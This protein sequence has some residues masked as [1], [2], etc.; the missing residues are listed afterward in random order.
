MFAPNPRG[1]GKA[2]SSLFKHLVPLMPDSWKVTFYT[3]RPGDYAC[4]G[5]TRTRCIDMRGDRFNAWENIRLPLA[6]LTDGINLLHCPSQTAPPLAPCPVILTVHDLIPLRMND[7]WSAVEVNRFRKALARSVAKSRRIITVSEFTKRDLMAFCRVPEDKVD[8]V[9]WGVDNASPSAFDEEQWRVFC[10]SAGIVSPYFIA[11]GG[12]APR[13]NVT[14]ILEAFARFV[15]EVSRDVQLLLV[16]VPSEA[17]EKF[18]AAAEVLDPSGSVVQLGY[19]P[20]ELIRQTLT[21]SEALVYPSLYEGFGLPI[22]EAMV[23]GA[24]VITSN[25]TSMPEIAGDAAL[26]VNPADPGAIADAMHE[27]FANR[28]LRAELK[29]RGFRRIDDFSW[30]LAARQTLASYSRALN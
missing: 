18:K 25:V 7:G 10:R 24:A 2:L 6:S 9:H 12:G 4:G 16:G 17:K 28:T 26:L 8:V 23:A 20:D 19:L 3:N 5:A 30:E 13:K 15:R 1:V 11:F 29:V 21:R 14:R 27:C 22:L